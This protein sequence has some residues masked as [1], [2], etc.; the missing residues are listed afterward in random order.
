MIQLN[1][2]IIRKENLEDI[3]Q[4]LTKVSKL[5]KNNKRK[6]YPKL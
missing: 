1:K 3:I 5:F 2:K 6:N 4:N